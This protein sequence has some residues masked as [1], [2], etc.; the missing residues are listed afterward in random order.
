HHERWDG[1]GYPDGLAGEAIPVLARIVA[2]ADA[3]DA[4]TSD[5]PYRKGMPA[6]VAFTEVER[7]RG[8][9]FDPQCAASFL[10]IRERIGQRMQTQ[11]ISVKPMANLM[12]A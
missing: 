2:V 10:A 8:Q 5:R 9:Q 1:K 4:M 11:I 12:R 6:D 3:F 7:Q